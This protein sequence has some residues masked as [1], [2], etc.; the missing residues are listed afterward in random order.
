MDEKLI[1]VQRRG[2]LCTLSFNRPT[3]RNALNP[4]MLLQ[5]TD[6]LKALSQEEE[7]R[8][9]VLRGVGEEAFSA[10]FDIGRIGEEGASQDVRVADP[11]QD[12]KEAIRGYPY[13]IIAMIYG[14]CVGGGL[15]LAVAC[16]LRIAAQDARLGITPAKLG[17]VYPPH[18]IAM[19]VDLVGPAFTNE[20]FFSG[21]LIPAQRAKT[22]G[23]V[24]EMVPKE[25][26]EEYTYK[27]S[28]EMVDNAPLSVKAS[29]RIVNRMLER[30]Y[31]R[32]SEEDQREFDELRAEAA[33]SRDLTDG[34]QAFLEKRKP[35]FLGH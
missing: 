1:L 8:G 11:Y 23:L 3:K 2:S 28:Q 15:E 31:Q 30:S 6:A 16:D 24:N 5:L 17:L 35:N 4:E 18:A 20:L 32:L 10:G 22:M 33:Q 19:F 9:V 13:P 7:V 34:Q 21:R 12:T 29:K 27:L 14:Y 26:L 25:E